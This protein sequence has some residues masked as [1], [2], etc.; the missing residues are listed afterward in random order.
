[1]W[2]GKVSKQVEYKVLC[3]NGLKLTGKGHPRSG[4]KL[5][6]HRERRNELEFDSWCLREGLSSFHEKWTFGEGDS[7]KGRGMLCYVVCA[8]H[9]PVCRSAS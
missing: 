7:T 8:T 2:E 3:K 4:R 6:A 5:K 1:M 9:S